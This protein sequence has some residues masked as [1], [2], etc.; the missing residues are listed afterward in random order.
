ME[1]DLVEKDKEKVRDKVKV[2]REAVVW[3]ALR[4]VDP[5][6]TVFVRSAGRGNHTNAVCLAS[7]ENVRSAELLWPGNNRPLL[8]NL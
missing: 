6:A 8:V 2:A 1:P 7:R 3:A 5:P 4:Q